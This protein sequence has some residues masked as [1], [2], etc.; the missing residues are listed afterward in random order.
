MRIL[1]QSDSSLFGS[2][3]FLVV[4]RTGMLLMADEPKRMLKELRHLK[5][6]TVQIVPFPIW[7]EY[8]VNDAD[9]TG[10]GHVDK[11][12]FGVEAFSECGEIV[13]P[14]NV[15]ELEILRARSPN[16]RAEIIAAGEAFKVCRDNREIVKMY[17]DPHYTVMPPGAVDLIVTDIGEFR[18]DASG[19]VD[20]SPCV[21]HVRDAVDEIRARLW[22][23]DCPLP[24]RNL[25]RD[26]REG[27][28]ALVCAIECSVTDGDEF[29]LDA[30]KRFR[31][32][33]QAGVK[34]ILI[35]GRSAG[36]GCALAHYLPGVCAVIAE[37]GAVL[38][39]ADGSG[40]TPIL[41]DRWQP[42][43][44]S[45]RMRP[46]LDCL[47][48]ALAHFP[49]AVPGDDNFTRITDRTIEVSDDV[50]PEVLA[51]IAKTRGVRH[52]YSSVHH[53]LS[54]SGLDKETGLAA[55]MAGEL[56]MA[57]L[58]LTAEVVTVGDSLN[59]APLFH[60]EAFAA[61]VGVRGVLKYRDV[62]GTR[63]PGY[64]TLNDASEGFLELADL[65]L[66]QRSTS[67]RREPF[68]RSGRR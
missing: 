46:V 58:L 20:L 35:T 42:E 43:E 30:L 38:V 19:R 53:H 5:A 29:S 17:A 41:L 22:P 1:K 48:E 34:V 23:P 16:R 44:L 32:L 8:L 64:V 61:T 14:Q 67:G 21:R 36:W 45:T 3:R 52:T 6:K 66:A 10:I 54:A 57:D 63:M 7:I 28:K 12:L 37:N 24:I 13:Y 31:E 4:E 15:N 60:R 26:I 18:P 25:A 62:L 65:L 50:D 59:D 55:A 39:G 56:D 40:S 2:L 11:L 33:H 51:A 27:V 49:R 9:G 68:A 47:A